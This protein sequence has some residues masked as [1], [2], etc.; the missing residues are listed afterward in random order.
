MKHF[1]LFCTFQVFFFGKGI[2]YIKISYYFCNTF[3]KTFFLS[4]VG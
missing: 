4:S 2:A 1:L 3:E